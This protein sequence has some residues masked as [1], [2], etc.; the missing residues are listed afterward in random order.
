M[1]E[2]QNAQFYTQLQDENMKSIFDCW[3]EALRRFF[4]VKGRTTRYEFWAFQTVSLFIFLLAALIG[5]VFN[6]YQVVFEIFALYFLAPATTISIRRLH[7]LGQSG[8]WAAPIVGCG[9]MLLFNSE[10]D[11]VNSIMLS[12]IT[13]SYMSYLYWL[14]SAEG[15][16]GEN[17]YGPC[18]YEPKIYD[19]DSRVFII[20]MIVFLVGLWLTFFIRIY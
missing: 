12:F 18:V 16:E 6:A 7:D 1:S 8:W 5:F 2:E 17:I 20:F 13:L 9:F 15:D 10:C 3:S 11:L 4:D 14:L 19:Q